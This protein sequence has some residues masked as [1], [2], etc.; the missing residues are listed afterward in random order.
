LSPIR[1]VLVGEIAVG[2]PPDEAFELFTPE[3]E[4]RWAE[5]WDPEWVDPAG[6]TRG[7]GAVFRT[8]HGG[9]ETIWVMVDGDRPAGRV[10]YVRD[11]PGSRIGTVEV[12]CAPAPGG[13]SLARV[14]YD[15]TALSPSGAEYL[16]RFESGYGE[17][18][19]SWE[20]EI[21]RALRRRPTGEVSPVR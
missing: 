6:A 1:I 4:R 3:G 11:T 7:V 16:A 13:G 18:L 15:L 12:R 10:R 20:R 19:A 5:G 2:A 8:R 21:A 14:T 9:E 17:M